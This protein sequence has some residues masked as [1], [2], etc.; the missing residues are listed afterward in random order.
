[1]VFNDCRFYCAPKFWVFCSEKSSEK[2]WYMNNSIFSNKTRKN[3]IGGPILSPKMLQ[4]ERRKSWK[5][6]KCIEIS[7]FSVE[8]GL[9]KATEQGNGALGDHFGCSKA[10]DTHLRDHNLDDFRGPGRTCDQKGGV[11]ERLWKCVLQFCCAIC[12]L[13]RFCWRINIDFHDVWIHLWSTLGT[14]ISG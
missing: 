14:Q 11:G 6:L 10:H 8:E 9:T 7:K 2:W 12:V 1:M 13:A 4:N 3:V 5:S